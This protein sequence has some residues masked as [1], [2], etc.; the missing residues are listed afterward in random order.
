MFDIIFASSMKH[1]LYLDTSDKKSLLLIIREDE[2]LAERS[3]DIQNNHG[4][5]INAHIEEMM[6]E[7]NLSWPQIDAICV[8]NG[9]G[10]Y[11]GL[12]I[13]L[14]TAKG[15]CY[16][17]TIPLI[18]LNKLDLIY[19]SVPKISDSSI[20]AIIKAREN[21]FFTAIYSADGQQKLPYSLLSKDELL[22]E[23]ETHQAILCAEDETH[24]AEFEQFTHVNVSF[25]DIISLCRTY[26]NEHKVAD[27][28][29]SEPFYLKNVYI[30]KINKL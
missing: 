7:C 28:L 18:L 1:L 26:F 8:L 14:A 20:C 29:H 23:I 5:I 2:V 19:Q 17:Q 30:N 27:L 16:A 11:T 10:S 6:I 3:N 15:L 4:Q 12:R 25:N 21:E 9:P 22:K 13:S 24:Q